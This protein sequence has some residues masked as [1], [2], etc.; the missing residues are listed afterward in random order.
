MH[1]R[2]P[3][4]LVGCWLESWLR[5]NSARISEQCA[6]SK[7]A[8]VGAYIRR[9]GMN[10]I[11]RTRVARLSRFRDV[12]V[13]LSW[14]RRGFKTR[15]IDVKEKRRCR[16][17]RLATQMR[18]RWMAEQTQFPFFPTCYHRNQM[19]GAVRHPDVT[20]HTIQPLASLTRKVTG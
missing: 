19:E 9:G 10:Q 2:F 6:R 12:E 5:R 13:K 14:W 11:V 3:D 18:P 1:P 17:E 16:F 15:S 7:E 8:P 4:M 20:F